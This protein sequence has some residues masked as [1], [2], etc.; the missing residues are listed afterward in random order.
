M[1]TTM[2]P[3]EKRVQISSVLGCV[4]REVVGWEWGRGTGGVEAV[5]GGRSAW[6]RL[7]G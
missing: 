7:L 5:R 1:M 4:S 3:R 2:K 6:G